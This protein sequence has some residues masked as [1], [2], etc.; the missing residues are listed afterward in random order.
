ML[1][2]YLEEEYIEK[3]F[4]RCETVKNEFYYVKMAQAWLIATTWVK[5]P[6]KQNNI[7][8]NLH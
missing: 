5:F 7:L 4:K 8:K 2:Y 6:K 1:S 3:V